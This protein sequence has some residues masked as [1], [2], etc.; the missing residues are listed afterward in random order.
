MGVV[1]QSFYIIGIAISTEDSSTMMNTA[2]A[3]PVF[4]SWLFM[5]IGLLGI[6]GI[7]DKIFK[8]K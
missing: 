1:L 5:I 6:F 7:I 4:F 3:P 8:K 2:Y